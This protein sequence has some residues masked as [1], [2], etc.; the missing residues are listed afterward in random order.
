MYR[1]VALA[2]GFLVL[3]AETRQASSEELERGAAI[4]DPSALRYLDRQSSFGL[5]AILLGDPQLS[6]QVSNEQ[7]FAMPAMAPVKQALQ[8]EF[9][10]YPQYH[11]KARP[12]AS[13]GVHRGGK[14]EPDYRLFDRSMLFSSRARFVLAGVINRMDRKYKSP[15]TC[16]E[17]RL[18]YRLSYAALVPTQGSSGEKKMERSLSS[19]LPMTLN[20][21]LNAKDSG[22]P[23]SC[24]EI[25]QAWLDIGKLSET[26]EALARRLTAAG[27]VLEWSKLGSIVR[28]ETNLQIARAPV[29]VVQDFGGHADYLLKVFDRVSRPSSK[30]FE[31]RETTLENQ[32]DRRVIADIKKRE[33]LIQWLLWPE[34]VRSL[35]SGQIVI[36]KE[37]LAKSAISVTPGGLGRSGNQH[38]FG[39]FTPPQGRGEEGYLTDKRIADA[40]KRAD[41]NGGVLKNIKGPRGFE[42]RLNDVSCIGCH[43]TRGIGGF[44]FLGTDWTFATPPNSIF[45]AGSP[46][47]FGDQPRRLDIL[48]A[49]ADKRTEDFSRGYSA[50]PQVR[51]SKEMPGSGYYN[52]WGATCYDKT[53]ANAEPVDASFAGWSCASGLQCRVIAKTPFSRRMGLCATVN[54]IGDPLEV[55]SIS[56]L[57]GFGKDVYTTE[58]PPLKN[59][60]LKPP[61]PAEQVASHQMH[62][63]GFGG[64]FGG[65]LRTKNCNNLAAYPD[66][67]CGKIAKDGFNNCINT[68]GNPL[69]FC[70]ANYTEE[71]GLRACDARRPCRDDYICVATDS[72]QKDKGTCIPPYF[73]FQFRV[74][75]HPRVPAP[76]E[77][78][79]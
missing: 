68:D 69:D 36:G 34:Q 27:S 53:V 45:V 61:N 44:H 23:R 9:R 60:P 52:G 18:I 17:I 46:H 12:G 48:K 47:F 19:R 77:D 25:A 79:E 3:I 57:K 62:Y 28:L 42:Q 4:T 51:G 22:D 78:I 15:D 31:F 64:F 58:V 73:V 35:D 13:L 59:Y 30:T 33:A 71:A 1:A 7:L 16:G 2:L 21:I 67:A 38:M 20:L 66:A 41:P 14:S 50:R 70:L 29:G 55:G 49:I 11:A 6:V 37:Y 54:R 26:G 10:D 40:I 8:K 43:Q 65:A 5:G 56:W 74:D 24:S 32:I 39:Y 76:P 72:K 63:K 75:G